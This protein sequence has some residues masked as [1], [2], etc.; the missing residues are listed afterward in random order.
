MAETCAWCGAA[1]RASLCVECGCEGPRDPDVLRFERMTWR[2]GTVPFAVM[3]QRLERRFALQVAILDEWA[4]REEVPAPI[5]VPSV[6]PVVA[7]APIAPRFH[8]PPAPPRPSREASLD[9]VQSVLLERVGWFVGGFLFVAPN[10]QRAKGPRPGPR[11][12]TCPR[13]ERELRLLRVGEP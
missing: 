6:A 9:T 10:L 12:G 7:A 11:G 8:L 1:I 3:K 5:E 2:P 13:S 4:S